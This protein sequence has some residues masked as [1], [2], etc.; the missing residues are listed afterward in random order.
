MGIVAALITVLAFAKLG[1]KSP[2]SVFAESVYV[3]QNIAKAEFTSQGEFQIRAEQDEDAPLKVLDA[4]VNVIMGDQYHDLTGLPGR[5]GEVISVPQ[6]VMKNVSNRRITGVGLIISDK[7]ANIK[8]GFYIRDQSILP[9]QNFTIRPE[10][11]V[12]V[13]GNP[14]KN[15]KFWLDAV[16]KARIT[17][18]VGAFFEDGSM[19][20]NRD[21]R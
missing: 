21:Q 18:R 5:M 6:V 20:V 1:T 10:N 14:A 19:W 11:L 4:R 12:R 9:G 2:S 8:R 13:G 16:D 7:A 17:V 3:S 15:P